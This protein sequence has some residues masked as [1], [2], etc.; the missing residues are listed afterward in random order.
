MMYPKSGFSLSAYLSGPPRLCG[1]R[2]KP[3]KRR[4]RGG[5][6]RYAEYSKMTSPFFSR[7]EF[8][9]VVIAL[10]TSM[11]CRPASNASAEAEIIRATERARLKA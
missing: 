3:D 2:A 4:V 9:I 1:K 11:A 7:I 10:A 8:V 6:L 5:P